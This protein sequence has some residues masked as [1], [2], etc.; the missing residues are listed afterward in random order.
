MPY[1]VPR[2]PL[3]ACPLPNQPGLA[4]ARQSKASSL[5]WLLESQK[6]PFGGRLDIL[7][8]HCAQQTW[9]D[10]VG[11]R[12]VR[13]NLWLCRLRLIGPDSCAYWPQRASNC[14]TER[15]GSRRSLQCLRAARRVDAL[16]A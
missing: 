16:L 6:I 9:A 7:T 15:P 10:E 5:L 1:V 11:S 3:H 8:T 13:V 4:Q 2:L 14:I 12:G